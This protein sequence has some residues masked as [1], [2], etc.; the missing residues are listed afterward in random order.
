[1]LVIVTTDQWQ[2]TGVCCGDDDSPLRTDN[3]GRDHTVNDTDLGECLAP[4]SLYSFVIASVLL[5]R[6]GGA[7]WGL[8]L[9]SDNDV[10][11]SMFYVVLQQD[12]QDQCTHRHQVIE[13]AL[14]NLL[15]PEVQY[16]MQAG[17]TVST[18]PS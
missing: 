4:S 11:C 18:S 10:V 16:A 9:A 14:V 1:M 2:P 12:Q 6:C 7:L 17:R 13:R 5:L 3:R 15:F 8:E